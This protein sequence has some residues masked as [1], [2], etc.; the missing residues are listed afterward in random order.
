MLFVYLFIQG[1]GAPVPEHQKGEPQH[2]TS[3]CQV[4]ALKRRQTMS[5]PFTVT[6]HIDLMQ[7]LLTAISLVSRTWALGLPRAAV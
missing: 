3:Q 5:K 4:S 1:D 2:V 7:L 6:V